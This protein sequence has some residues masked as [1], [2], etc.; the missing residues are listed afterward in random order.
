MA[1]AVVQRACGLLASLPIQL[2]SPCEIVLG[3]VTNDG[4]ARDLLLVASPNALLV[5]DLAW[6]LQV[7]THGRGKFRAVSLC[8]G[9]WQG[10]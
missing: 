1:R 8:G 7:D 10:L 3:A 6:V 4:F 5:F 9:V 2:V